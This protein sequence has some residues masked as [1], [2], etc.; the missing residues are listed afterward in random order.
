[1]YKAPKIE[2]KKILWEGKYLRSFALT[3]N[4]SKGVTV[5]WEAIERVG[6]KGIACVIPITV[7]KRVVM[8]KQFRPPVGKFVIEFPAGLNDKDEPLIEVAKRELFEETGYKADTLTEIAV[9]P[10]SAG[11]SGEVLTIYLAKD[12]YLNGGQVLDDAEEI[13]VFTV[14]MDRFN[15]DVK[16]LER[17]D[18]YVDLKIYGLFDYAMRYYDRTAKQQIAE[19]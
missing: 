18:T 15:E 17:D 13:E 3:L 2:D 10:I 14:S 4:N 19:I 11:L 16:G 7:D 8:I 5:S 6:C 1:M 9:G 12:V